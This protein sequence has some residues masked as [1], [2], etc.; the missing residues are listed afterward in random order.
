MQKM[1]AERGIG[2]PSLT[3]KGVADEKGFYLGDKDEVWGLF[4][5]F[6]VFLVCFFKNYI[7]RWTRYIV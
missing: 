4:G 3:V 2:A 6:V 5:E 7:L 1:L